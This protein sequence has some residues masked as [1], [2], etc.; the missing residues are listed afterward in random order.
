[1]GRYTTQKFQG[2]YRPQHL[3]VHFTSCS[4]GMM[5]RPISAVF[6]STISA[7]W[8]I[9]YATSYIESM[10][11]CSSSTVRLRHSYDSKIWEALGSRTLIRNH[12]PDQQPRFQ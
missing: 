7:R 9:V 1:M 11:T 3:K 10:N 8:E 5:I 12:A 2:N 6:V 4:P